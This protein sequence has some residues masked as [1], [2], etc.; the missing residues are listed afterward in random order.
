MRIWKSGGHQ[1]GKMC[2]LPNISRP[3]VI[4][5]GLDA[6]R[7]IS[8]VA[9]SGLRRRLRGLERGQLLPA[10]LAKLR[11]R[12]LGGAKGDKLIRCHP[13]GLIGTHKFGKGLQ[14]GDH[15]G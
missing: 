15:L 13:I 11:Q 8:G 7:P 4:A 6:I 2:V 14:S 9:F 3:A 1:M 12:P 10:N 5:A